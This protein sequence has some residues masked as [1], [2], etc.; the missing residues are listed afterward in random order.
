ME[1]ERWRRVEQLYHSALKVSSDR[2]RA[3][4]EEQC[5]GDDE[6]RKEVASL[7]SYESSAAEFIESP[8]FDV[9]AK[10]L[11]EERSVK[12]TATQG[13]IG[14]ALPRFRILEKL[15]SG[16][17][18][19]VY[20]AEDTKLRRTVALKFL[21]A[22]VS[23]DPQA[24]E[25][26]QREAYAATALN[27]PNICTVYDVDEFQGR[28][29]IAME[30]L[31]GQTLEH[32][33]A[34][35]PLPLA[36]LL[37][38]A[39]Q[40]SDALEAAH[41]SGVIHRDI[42]PSNIFVSPRGQAKVLD[43]GLAKKIKPRR[44]PQTV[45]SNRE[46]VSIAEENLT[47]PG[48]AIGTVA[49]MSPEQA[50]GEDLDT[51]TDLFSFG[52]IVYEMATGK[53]PFSG[54]A[55]VVIFDAI[56][57]RTPVPPR[58]LNPELPDKLVEIISKALEK[59]RDLRYQ[60]A[61]EMRA[62]LRRLK[63]DSESGRSLRREVNEAQQGSSSAPMVRPS[64]A[65]NSVGWLRS[66]WRLFAGTFS[67]LLISFAVVLWFAKLR[68][69]PKPD[70]R[71]LQL[72][73]N[74]SENP[75][76]SGAISPDGKY[77]AYSDTKSIYL[78]LIATGETLVV[79]EPDISKEGKVEWETGPWF[80]DSSRFLVSSHPSG[81]AAPGP[82]IQE[83]STIW[84]ASILGRAPRKLREH[85]LLWSI[86]PSGTLISYGT[87]LGKFG[88][89]EIWLM[90]PNGENAK[91]LYDADE[92]SAIC[93]VA[94]SPGGQRILYVRTDQ[95]GET[96][97]TRDLQNGSVTQVLSPSE[98]H[99]I[100]DFAWLADGRLLYAKWESG[101]SSCNFWDMPLDEVTGRPTRVAR[102]LTNWSGFCMN[103]ISMTADGKKYAFLKWVGHLTSYMAELAAPDKRLLNFRH[104]PL[105]ES[106]DGLTT[107]MPDS[108]AIILI[109]DRT[110]RFGLYKQALDADTA[111]GPL[112]SPPD[113]TRNAR[114]TPDG[115]WI[116][117]FGVGKEGGWPDHP[118]PVMRVPVDG[119]PSQEMF[120]A[121]T[122]SLFTCPISRSATCVI[123]EPTQDNKQLIVA[124]LDPM[125]G[126]GPELARFD[127]DPN[128]KD[129]WIEI[130]PDGTRLALLRTPTEPI[131][132]VGLNGQRIQQIQIKGW[133]NLRAFYW[134]PDGKGLYVVATVRGGRVVLYVDFQGNA[135]VIWNNTGGSSE[136][137]AIPSPD[138][139]HLAMQAWATNGNIWTLENF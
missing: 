95:S 134:E 4:L 117:Y 98:L 79:P 69:T 62:D 97:V 63:R 52:A 136:T 129:W 12:E 14:A 92:N 113:G 33:I 88:H 7:L 124:T 23:R 16:G 100:N 24:L 77:L 46:T 15:G 127:L 102:Q 115:K 61:S 81:F 126:R 90:G 85:A 32:R 55:S 40:I 106:S 1:S 64:S 128:V 31:E 50:R 71:Q 48:I 41:T 35:R 30:L 11:A 119:G 60:V 114:V 110:G 47:S 105:T 118:E 25:R 66:H 131:Q 57:N 19:V 37:E 68:L 91:K 13:M 18:G 6:L 28:P 99:G 42:K 78:K 138:G 101:G 38:L 116:L 139:R 93:C 21:P 65:T 87:N 70:L 94:W 8:A 49:Y 22:D 122:W 43:F 83:N 80:P 3:F 73:N 51:R 82:T 5:Q 39:I 36:E 54:S 27:H 132:I 96:L 120:V 17:M 53:P 10:L 86:S 84:V 72:T 29:F 58:S 130:S 44:F 67:I 108:K 104:F 75:V 103:G 89:H 137:M 2:R 112:V 26:F 125:K 135:Q 109:S 111:E 133:S 9:A 56:L 74:S 20:K 59:D 121:A 76:R 34:A 107:W 45:G 123:A